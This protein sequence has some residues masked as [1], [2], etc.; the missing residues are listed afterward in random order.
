VC[1]CGSIFLFCS[2]YSFGWA[3]GDVEG[4]E[5]QSSNSHFGLMLLP[6]RYGR[7]CPGHPPPTV[8]AQMARHRTGHDG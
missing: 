3:N 8:G 2:D 4:F 7:A 1:I 6:Y 5:M